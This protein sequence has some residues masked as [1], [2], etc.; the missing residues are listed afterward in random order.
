MIATFKI[1]TIVDIYRK[2]LLFV[3]I[4]LLIRRSLR[5]VTMHQELAF[6]ALGGQY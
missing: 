1:T 3:E 5:L 4:A 6:S 2:F